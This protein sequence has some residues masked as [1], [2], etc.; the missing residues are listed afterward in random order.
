MDPPKKHKI[1]IERLDMVQRCNLSKKSQR[2][3]VDIIDNNVR[4]CLK[5]FRD[6]KNG[7]NRES[8]VRKVDKDIQNIIM[9]V[10]SHLTKV[11]E[12]EVAI[13]EQESQPQDNQSLPAIMDKE[14]E[15]VAKEVIGVKLPK[16]DK[17]TL[18]PSK[19]FQLVLNK[20]D[21][22]EEVEIQYNK[23][24][25]KPRLESASSA[26]PHKEDMAK[27]VNSF[28]SPHCTVSKDEDT[29]LQE[30]LSQGPIED[31]RKRKT[32]K[33]SLKRPASAS[34]PSAVEAA[35]ASKE[36]VKKTKNKPKQESKSGQKT[37]AQT[38]KKDLS[39][40]TTMKPAPKKKPA[41]DVSPPNSSPL[42]RAPDKDPDILGEHIFEGM[43]DMTDGWARVRHV[44]KAELIM[45]T[46][47][48]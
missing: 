39:P 21:T 23:P 19:L 48:S 38:V 9:T 14:P 41:A 16:T 31:L 5:H 32:K 43:W 27:G 37:E 33:K 45:N 46:S 30:A 35:P 34:K 6:F 44:L 36:A 28:L 47:K 15:V 1:A 3:F 12:I 8:A 22:D 18:S 10:L 24:P 11:T 13:D 7:V 26:I 42:T 29:L 4:C 17:K 2:D 20:G 40:V 25:K